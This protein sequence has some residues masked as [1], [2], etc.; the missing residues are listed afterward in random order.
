MKMSINSGDATGFT[1][2]LLASKSY[3]H[4]ILVKMRVSLDKPTISSVAC[5][6]WWGDS[7]L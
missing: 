6:K 3:R 7:R 1:L 5:N 2:S 4:F